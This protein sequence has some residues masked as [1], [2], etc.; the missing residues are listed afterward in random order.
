ML[1]PID[2]VIAEVRKIPGATWI[3]ADPARP[4]VLRPRDAAKLVQATPGPIF[5]DS[6][7]TP[8]SSPSWGEAVNAVRRCLAPSTEEAALGGPAGMDA[9]AWYVS[10]H[11]SRD[12][13]G[14]YIPLSSLPIVDEL[15]FAHL[16]LPRVERWQLIWAALLAHEAVHFAVDWACAWFEL[17]H[18]APLRGAVYDRMQTSWPAGGALLPRSSYF[19][20]EEALANGHVLRALGPRVG[21]AAEALRRFI[22]GQPPGYRDGEA[23]ETDTRFAATAAE[24]L[25]GYL[26]VW[27]T[28]WN[29]DPGN[30]A[31]DFSRIL[32]LD[33]AAL[34]HCPVWVLDDLAAVDLSAG[35]VR[36]FTCVAPIEETPGFH[37]K[38][39][40]QRLEDA[41]KRTKARLAEGIPNGSDFKKWPKAG[42]R[43]W[44]IRVTD[45]VRAH[46]RQPEDPQSEPWRACDIGDHK[47]MGHG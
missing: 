13:W 32:P 25:R 7:F 30:P 46:L 8:P 4:P 35:A 3:T 31:L 23:A 1:I 24:V 40:R 42:D 16:P 36:L 44:S 12:R 5:D 11:G 29:L 9:V 14:I 39:K 19:E 17:L 37:K 18:H 2:D 27:S 22:R 26:S 41:W 6:G 43:M 38:A 20:A 28:A 10:F 45:G 33:A 21:S 47:A 15:H 34:A